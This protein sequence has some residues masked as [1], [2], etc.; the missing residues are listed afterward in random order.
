MLFHHLRLLEFFCFLQNFK[1]LSNLDV[2][3][4]F[5]IQ[6]GH[7]VYFFNFLFDRERKSERMVSLTRSDSNLA[8]KKKMTIKI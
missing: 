1:Y 6:T 4:N 3:G 8:N 7:E 2:K 5:K